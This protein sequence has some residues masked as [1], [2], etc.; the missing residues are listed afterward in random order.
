MHTR[1]KVVTACLLLGFIHMIPTPVALASI[2][3]YN[4]FSQPRHITDL[5]IG[6]LG[7]YDVTITYNSSFD[8]VFGSGNPPAASTPEFWGSPSDAAVAITAIRDAL[9]A[10]FVPPT[11]TLTEIITPYGSDH[12]QFV[13]SWRLL[14]GPTSTEYPTHVW[15][16]LR[17]SIGGQSWGWT[18]FE[19]S[20]SPIPEPSTL[21]I[22]SLLAVL[23]LGV[24]WWRRRKAA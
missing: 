4:A 9:N 22:W 16:N 3:T 2:V 6:T 10:D 14:V 1:I 5:Q 18:T 8:I 24:A 17:R 13:Y 23:G 21:I 7:T 11:G 19:Q 20:T 15:G 12:V